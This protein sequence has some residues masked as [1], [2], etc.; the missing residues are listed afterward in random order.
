MFIKKNEK[1]TK[2]KFLNGELSELICIPPNIAD[3]II[4]YGDEKLK[5]I[6]ML[7]NQKCSYM[8]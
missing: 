1:K 5:D 4:C 3:N 7:K 6:K 8:L 2:E